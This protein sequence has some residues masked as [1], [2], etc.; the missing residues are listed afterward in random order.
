MRAS[1]I[2]PTHSTTACQTTSHSDDSNNTSD[3]ASPLS[4]TC[5][6]SKPHL[7]TR[8]R[9]FHQRW[10]QHLHSHLPF[11]LAHRRHSTSHRHLQKLPGQRNMCLRDALRPHNTTP[12]SPIPIH[13]RQPRDPSSRRPRRPLP[14]PHDTIPLRQGTASTMCESRAFL[15]ILRRASI[16]GQTA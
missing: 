8:S 1:A 11:R 4:L 13:H 5:Q 7:P 2:T 3:S 14:R 12:P 16:S 9:P 6:P 15:C 10:H